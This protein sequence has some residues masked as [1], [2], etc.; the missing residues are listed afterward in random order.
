MQLVNPN[1]MYTCLMLSLKVTSHHTDYQVA[2]C[3][4]M[5][6]LSSDQTQIICCFLGD[7]IL[8]SFLGGGL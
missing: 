3:G 5:R 7:E 6:Y 1:D 2:H 4:S 8:P